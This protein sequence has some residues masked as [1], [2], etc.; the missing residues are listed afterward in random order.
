VSTPHR[1]H[2]PEQQQENRF[3]TTDLLL[4]LMT[5]IWGSNFTVIKYSLDDMLPLAFNGLRF[6]IAS[7]VILVALRL[8]SRGPKVA[9]ADLWKLFGIG[10]IGNTFYQSVFILGLAR[11]RAGNGALIIATTPLFTALYERLRGQ[12]YFTRMGIVGLW[13]AF[14]GIVLVIAGGKSEVS[15]R[16]TALGDLMVLSATVSWV[17]YTVGSR[18]L[19]EKYGPVKATAIMMASGTPP[20]LLICAP[21]LLRQDWSRVGGLAWGGVVYSALLAIALAYLIWNYGV[22]RIGSTRT[23]IYS[24]FTPVVAMLVAW[25]ALGEVPTAGQ[26]IGAAVIFAGIYLVRG[27]MIA[28]KPPGH[29]P[30]AQ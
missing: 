11:T 24:N 13:L 5:I 16:E 2:T 14:S 4:L 9:R 30:S 23:A 26:L 7:S 22:K 15:F 12:E 27:G 3:G 6:V 28:G 8:A 21:S 10:L 18:P 1:N 19:V 29:R 20:L 17:F 25:P